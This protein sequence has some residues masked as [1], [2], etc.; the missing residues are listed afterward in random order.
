[1]S[2]ENVDVVREAWRV[3]IER[4]IDGATQYYAQD[5]VVEALPEAPDRTTRKGWDGMRRRHR[6]FYEAWEDVNW[7]PVEFIDAGDDIVVAE[8]AMRALGHGS[9]APVDRPFGFV[10]ELRDGKI[11]RDRPFTS[12]SRAREA[13]GLRE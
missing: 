3:F 12:K 5:C 7:E 2:R 4:G 10:Y 13:A 11:V 6:E 8:I 1:M 9:G